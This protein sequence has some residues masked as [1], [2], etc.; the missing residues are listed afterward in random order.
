MGDCLLCNL[1]SIDRVLSTFGRLARQSFLILDKYYVELILK[2]ISILV[3][4]IPLKQP[5]YPG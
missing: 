1:S 3:P 4:H 5:L 2:I